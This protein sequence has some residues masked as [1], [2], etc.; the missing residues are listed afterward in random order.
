MSWIAHAALWHVVSV[1]CNF[2]CAA[3]V[4]EHVLGFRRSRAFTKK[5]IRDA[6]GPYLFRNRRRDELV[7]NDTP[8]VAASSAA[9]FQQAGLI[10]YARGRITVLDRPGLEK[11]SCECYWVVRKEYGRLLPAKFV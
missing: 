9:A 7:L 6:Q 4:L 8:S 1:R 11:R 2:R 5:I 10:R 3:Q